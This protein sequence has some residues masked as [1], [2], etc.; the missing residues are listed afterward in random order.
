MGI[1]LYAV[2]NLKSCVIQVQNM[3][4]SGASD[5]DIMEKAKKLLMQDPKL[6]K[7]FKFDHVWLLMKDIPKFSDNIN[8]GIPDIESDTVGSPASQSPGSSSN[9][10]QRPI[11]SKKAK[12]KRKLSEGNTSSMDNVDSANEQILDFLKESASSRE[13]TYEMVQLHMQ[14]QAKKIALEEMEAEN[15]ILLKILNSIDDINTREFIRAE[16]VRIIQKRT[17]QQQ[18]EENAQNSYREYFGD[19][20]GS[21]PNLP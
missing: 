5:Q 15:K 18:T 4:P 2:R 14:N 21:R 3:H 7:V 16:Q 20:G 12:L 13:K 9:S 6:K 17:Q 19:F 1:I 10:S 11:G 8:V